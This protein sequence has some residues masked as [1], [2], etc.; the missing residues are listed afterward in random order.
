MEM[1]VKYRWFMKNAVNRTKSAVKHASWYLRGRLAQRK[2]AGFSMIPPDMYATNIALL[3][4]LRAARGCVIECG[5]WRG[6]MIAGMADVLGPQREYH[7]LDSFEGLP[8]AQEID[9]ERAAAYQADPGSPQYFDNCRAEVEYA[10][11]AMSMSRARTKYF[12]Q[13]WVA[14]TLPTLQIPADGIAVL[15]IDADWYQPTLECLE[16]LYPQVVA[17]GLV[18]LDDYGYWE[19]TSKAVHRYL[20]ERDL[21]VTISTE[22]SVAHIKV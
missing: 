10:K 16:A 13:G 17:G 19:G 21:P 7:L 18:I 12:H 2:Y 22:G 14:D 9:G 11:R 3:R 5:V 20:A 1:G 4:H 6:G 8:P 15:R